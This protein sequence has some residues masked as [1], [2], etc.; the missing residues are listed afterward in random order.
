M[1]TG[2]KVM[3]NYE[4][5][6]HPASHLETIHQIEVG[7]EKGRRI[8]LL[9]LYSLIQSFSPLHIW[10][11]IQ[12]FQGAIREAIFCILASCLKEAGGQQ[13]SLGMRFVRSDLGQEPGTTDE[14]PVMAG[15]LW[16][17]QIPTQPPHPFQPQ[18]AVC[19]E[20]AWGWGAGEAVWDISR[21]TQIRLVWS[22]L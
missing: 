8:Y 6:A 10:V 2:H 21:T 20:P 22:C 14:V 9:S 5:V 4:P 7:V 12:P 3:K 17:H 18:E 13:P 1:G 16:P 11:V 15:K 19:S